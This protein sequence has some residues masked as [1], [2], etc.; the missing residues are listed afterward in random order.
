M[1]EKFIDPKD[2][3]RKVFRIMDPGMTQVCTKF[4]LDIGVV[5][6][7]KV[8]VSEIVLAVSLVVN[9]YPIRLGEVKEGENQTSNPKGGNLA[10]TIMVVFLDI[11]IQLFQER[12]I[13]E[14]QSVGLCVCTGD[15]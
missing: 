14:I 11:C 1:W 7:A 4:D 10:T 3:H 8:Q 9:P 2:G 13:S 15:I 6:C 12:V 5:R